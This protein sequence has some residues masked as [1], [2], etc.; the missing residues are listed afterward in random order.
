MCSTVLAPVYRT[1]GTVFRH[2]A[3]VFVEQPMKKQVGCGWTSYVSV[4]LSTLNTLGGVYS[5]GCVYVASTNRT[6]GEEIVADGGGGWNK[7]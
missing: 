5:T 3:R 2:S 1:V 6:S 4:L 7:W